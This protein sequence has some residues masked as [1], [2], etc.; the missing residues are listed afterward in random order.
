LDAICA[1]PTEAILLVDCY[2][3]VT[4]SVLCA[5]LLLVYSHFL[6][7]GLEHFNDPLFMKIFNWGKLLAQIGL[8]FGI[9]G[10]WRPSALQW[11]APACAIATLMFWLCTGGA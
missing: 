5:V 3:F 2:A 6:G 10:V 9:G 11:H 8:L 1:T 7:R 4:A